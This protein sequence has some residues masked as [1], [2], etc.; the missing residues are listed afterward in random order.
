LSNEKKIKLFYKKQYEE[1]GEWYDFIIKTIQE[2]SQ[3]KTFT[4]TA[5]QLYINELGKNGF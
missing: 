3:N 5:K 1:E 2:N 4:Y